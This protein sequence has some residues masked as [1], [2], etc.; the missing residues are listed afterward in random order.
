VTLRGGAPLPRVARSTA[1]ASVQIVT[2]AGPIAVHGFTIVVGSSQQPLP[3]AVKGP[4]G[5]APARTAIAGLQAVPPAQTP[6]RP[7][8]EI[9]TVVDIGAAF[10]VQLSGLTDAT[11]AV[12]PPGSTVKVAGESS[13]EHDTFVGG[14]AAAHGSHALA[15]AGAI[16]TTARDHV[17]SAWYRQPRHL[18]QRAGENL[19]SGAI[20]SQTAR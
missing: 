12:T 20:G 2:V 8:E 10:P 16:A 9:H 14:E 19:V 17:I 13:N 1:I 4:C 15:S 6:G 3:D 18:R 7:G 5:F 11:T